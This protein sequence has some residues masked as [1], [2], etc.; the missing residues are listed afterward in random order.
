[1][2][3]HLKRARNSLERLAAAFHAADVSFF[4]GFV[5]PPYGGGNQ[6]LRALWKE[7]ERRGWRLENN[8]I[9]PVT[10]A[11]VYNSFNFDF[12]RLRAFR[13]PQCRMVHRVDGPVS[14]YRG[15]DDGIDRRIW[16]INRDLADV[17]VFQSDYSRRQHAAMGL[18]FKR[19]TVI[20][21]A[22]DPDIFHSRGRIPFD[23]SRRTRLIATSWSD[24]ANK[25]ADVLAWLDARLD[26]NRYELT[27]LGRSPVTFPRARVLPPVNS[28]AVALELR[29][30]DVFVTASLHESCSN[31]VIE[32]LSCGLPVLYVDS[33]SNGELVKE[34]GLAFAVREEVPSRLDQLVA[35]YELRQSRIEPPRLEDVANR[36]LAVMGLPARSDR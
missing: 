35:E 33:G 22:A 36:Y 15:Q 32:A 1:V 12:D 2:K 10:Q 26:P 29:G 24:N 34:A 7:L 25:G 4:H 30:H 11:C 28:E 17:T 3:T 20:H 5:P 8:T 9:S 19:E 18:A 6:F 27:F 13:R 14:V 31:A 23:R 16:E 21:N